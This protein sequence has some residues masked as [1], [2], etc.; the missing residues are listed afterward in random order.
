MGFHSVILNP[1]SVNRVTPPTTTMPN[2]RVAEIISH[3]PTPL[4]GRMGSPSE[5]L[6][7]SLGRGGV[8]LTVG[9]ARGLSGTLD[10]GGRSDLADA[11]GTRLDA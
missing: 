7:D 6:T 4:V 10:F 2:T 9:A 5:G 8:G 1:D 11:V 3:I